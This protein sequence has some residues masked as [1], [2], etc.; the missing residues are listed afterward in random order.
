MIERLFRNHAAF[1]AVLFALF[2]LQVVLRSSSDVNH[3]AAWYLYVAQGL[4]NGKAMYRD[5]M[6]VNPPLAAWETL[7]LAYV[8][9]S[10]GLGIVGVFN[11]GVFG[12]TALS[13]ALVYRYLALGGSQSTAATRLTVVLVAT[14]LLYFPG[15]SFGER[16]HILVLLFLPWL[17]LRA[18]RAKGAVVGFPEAVAV[19]LL[20]SAGICLKPHALLAPLAAEAALMAL[21]RDWRRL[22]APENFAASLAAVAYV[23]A[24][25]I[26]TPDFF[27]TM[28]QLGVH[29][30]VPFIGFDRA[31]IVLGSIGAFGTLLV[32]AVLF[33]LS[34]G[35]DRQV[36]AATLAAAA[37]FLIAYFIQGKGFSY[38][39]LPATMLAAIS[40][41][42]VLADRMKIAAPPRISRA[43]AL[44]L[45]ML[46]FAANIHGQSYFY[47]SDGFEE[48]IAKVRPNTRSL[49]I[50]TTNL[51]L[52]F[53]L[54]TR[55]GY[56]WTSR[57]PAQWLIPY[58]STK[59]HAGPLPDDDIVTRSLDWTVSDLIAGRPDIVIVDRSPEQAYVPGGSFDYIGFWSQDPRFRPFWQDYAL[60]E[61][62]MDFV[63]YTRR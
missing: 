54:V 32:A 47:L 57:F 45:T 36:A 8:A 42:A 40:A 27:S 39:L 33:R 16:E 17:F 37:G 38:Q 62:I 12:L 60:R 41:T 18:A 22:L 9:N 46:L 30:Y 5:F 26:F 43:V 53:P 58:V 34:G 24:V 55:N 6:E 52:A 25:R 28:L 63:V 50:A 21:H 4:M 59:W 10:S 3:D 49:F 11:A 15:G 29:A 14:A 20:A 7:P 2:G 56:A 13:L 31:T 23:V 19:G 61:T 44:S 51:S 35:A 48:V 1:W